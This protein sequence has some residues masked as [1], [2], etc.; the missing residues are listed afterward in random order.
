[1][2]AERYQ[3]MSAVQLDFRYVVTEYKTVKPSDIWVLNDFGDNRL[4]VV[5]CTDD[6]EYRQVVVGMLK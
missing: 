5:S 4:T 6:G 1:M 3:I 2:K